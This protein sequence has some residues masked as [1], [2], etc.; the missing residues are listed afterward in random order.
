[1]P[2]LIER[3]A[4][5]K[6]ED[7]S[8]VIHIADKKKTPFFSAVKKGTKPTNT[9]T[10]WPVDGYPDPTTEGAVDEQDVTSFENLGTPDA[11][12]QGRVQ[13]FERKPK[14]SRL[15]ELVANQAGVGTRKAYA[16]SVA[17]ALVMIVR[18]IETTALGDNESRV[19]TSSLGGRMRGLGK[20]IQATAQSDLPVPADYRPAAAAIYSGNLSDLDDDDLIAVMQS[21]YDNTGDDEM[22]LM[23]FA[24]SLAKRR[25]SKLTAYTKDE[26][27]YTAVRRYNETGGKVIRHKVDLLDTDF[28]QGIIRLSSFIN[29]GGTPKTDASKRLAHFV[30]MD[31]VSM[32][33]AE[34]PNV[35]ELPNMGG[36]RR[37]LVQAIGTLEV[38]NPLFNGALK[39]AGA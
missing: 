12:L 26:T 16:K 20:W 8:D 7:L 17:K 25:M 15:A 13:I 3:D 27:G 19:G 35:M 23:I 32:R 37:A 10:E 11:V 36:G 21:I 30:N 29:T 24:G 39:P 5:A 31:T 34:N 2:Q 1:M 9:L 28:G 6:R 33:F 18:D 14:V 22:Q 4:V 38:G